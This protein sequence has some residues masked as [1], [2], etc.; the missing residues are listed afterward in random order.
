MRFDSVYV[1]HFKCNWKRLVD[2]PN[3]WGYTRDLY[4]QP[5]VSETVD[6]EY[7]KEHY[8]K[9]HETVNPTAIIPIGPE[10]DFTSPH[11]REQLGPD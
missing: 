1:G 5:G 4:Q 9:S 2:Y 6:F 10:I 3:L 7:N 11:N 8:Y